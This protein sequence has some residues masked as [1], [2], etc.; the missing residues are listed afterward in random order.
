[1]ASRIFELKILVDLKFLKVLSV[2]RSYA[3]YPPKNL[4][5]FSV[6]I[7]GDCN[8]LSEFIVLYIRVCRLT[9]TVFTRANFKVSAFS[10]YIVIF[11]RLSLQLESF[12]ISV[13]LSGV[14]K[15][16]VTLKNLTT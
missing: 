4:K 2:F 13:D 10:I 3:L 7:I 9:G 14:M 5:I 11:L 6:L 8:D 15:R 12:D 16:E 1:M